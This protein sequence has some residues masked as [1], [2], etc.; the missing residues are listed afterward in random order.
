LLAAACGDRGSLNAGGAADADRPTDGGAGGSGGARSPG[1]TPADGAV[2][3]PADSD[4]G[5]VVTPADARPADGATPAPLLDG[6][7]PATDGPSPPPPVDAGGPALISLDVIPPALNI[8]VGQTTLV[9]VLGT[10]AGGLR[11]DVS[12]EASWTSADPSIATIATTTRPGARVMGVRVGSTV[13]TV[14]HS[15]QKVTVPVSVTTAPVGAVEVQPDRPGVGIGETLQLKALAY[16]FVGAA[17]D[18]TAQATWK[19]SDPAIASV[20]S[21]GL[22]TCNAMGVVVVTASYMDQSGSTQLFCSKPRQLVALTLQPSTVMLQVGEGVTLTAL[23]IFSDGTAE[24]VGNDATFSS[25]DGRVAE[26]SGSEVQGVAPGT[27]T[28][29]A[30]YM[31]LAATATVKVVSDR[32]V[33]LELQPPTAVVRVGD[34]VDLTLYGIFSDG[35]ADTVDADSWTSSAP[36]VATVDGGSVAGKS[37]GKATITAT[38]M[39]LK[40]SAEITVGST[41][42]TGLKLLP[43]QP[44][45]HVDQS[46][47]LTALALYAGG[48]SVDV[49]GEVFWGSS[50]PKVA[51]VQKDSSTV[52]G[53]QPGTS[54]ITAQ[55]Q[56]V[57]DSVVVTVEAGG[58]KALI[59]TP[60]TVV[61]AVN[62]SFSFHVL[63][64]YTDGTSQDVTGEANWR[65]NDTSVVEVDAGRVTGFRPG[66]AKVTAT[67]AGLS[68]TTTVTVSA[69]R[70]ES[71]AISPSPAA[72]PVAQSRALALMGTFDDG[73]TR[74]LTARATWISSDAGVVLVTS[75]GGAPGTLTGVAAGTASV[76]A[77]YQ[78]QRASVAVTVAP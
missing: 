50:D 44:R 52:I 23:A 33:S 38:F 57:K 55:Y 46:V 17:T 58:I 14:V 66:S 25:S 15:T 68:I 7:R 9:R 43:P 31:N 10:F 26:V 41:E 48:A 76:T 24:D 6:P 5:S 45:L 11:R 28:V 40:A 72:V 32:P 53:L 27:A 22:A 18:V 69:A 56:G 59:M 19:S 73:T 34:T 42:L 49:S 30:S 2:N 1:A 77:T 3:R 64:E 37:A 20:S 78:G 71:L 62:E 8:Y 13:L 36:G 16:T 12:A 70:L 21:G 61:L 51:V 67:S 60:T 35:H 47:T 74:D 29:K 63:L 65:S 75:G 4:A 39:G 54:T